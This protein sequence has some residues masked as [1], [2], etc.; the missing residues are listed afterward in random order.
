MNTPAQ[1][2]L[3]RLLP[4]TW[5]LSATP[6]AHAAN[7]LSILIPDKKYAFSFEAQKDKLRFAPGGFPALPEQLAEV[8]AITQVLFDAKINKL[9]NVRRFIIPGAL[10]TQIGPAEIVGKYEHDI[11]RTARF[12]RS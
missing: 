4:L 7:Q 6:V 5:I 12:S 2:Q 3:I 8:K 9:V 11:R 10:H 1:T